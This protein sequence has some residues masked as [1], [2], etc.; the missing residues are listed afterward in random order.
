VK[1]GRAKK[2]LDIWQLPWEYVTDPKAKY[3]NDN[4]FL[5]E[6]LR[7]ILDESCLSA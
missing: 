3:E 6:I 1:A 7:V 2:L 5:K 4:F